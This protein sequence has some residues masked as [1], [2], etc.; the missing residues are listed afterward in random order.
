VGT[1]GG[2]LVAWWCVPPLVRATAPGPA[3]LPTALAPDLVA[4]LGVAGVA[5]AL[6]AVVVVAYGAQVARQVRAATRVEDD[7]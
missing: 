1:A 4:V 6:L 2:L 5:I 3:A 7:R